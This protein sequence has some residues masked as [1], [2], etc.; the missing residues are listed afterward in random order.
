MKSGFR[1]FYDKI[2]GVLGF[3]DSD[4]KEAKEEVFAAGDEAVP[5]SKAK[6]DLNAKKLRRLVSSNGSIIKGHPLRGNIVFH[7][8]R[9]LKEYDR[10]STASAKEEGD[11]MT[12]GEDRA[13][14]LLDAAIEKI[15]ATAVGADSDA[16]LGVSGG[17]YALG[18]KAQALLLA[19]EVVARNHDKAL[20]D[21]AIETLALEVSTGDSAKQAVAEAFA[22]YMAARAW[23]AR[24][25]KARAAV[26]DE[27]DA[28]AFIGHGEL[29]SSIKRHA[30]SG[31]PRALIAYQVMSLL[32]E[33]KKLK[34]M[35]EDVMGGEPGS[36]DIQ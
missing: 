13:A 17:E 8:S 20:I 34:G 25:L 35:V 36:I 18:V 1:R 12:R 27:M 29:I 10:Y 24:H 11:S 21:E 31:D 5:A 9:A 33:P 3:S 6:T 7:A 23:I 4:I 19:D 2:K 28:A 32:A 16:L 26:A 22:A 30:A 14:A 15:E